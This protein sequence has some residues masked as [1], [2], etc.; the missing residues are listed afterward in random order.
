ML[1][2]VEEDRV[3]LPVP[4]LERRAQA[5]DRAADVD[6]GVLLLRIELAAVAAEELQEVLAAVAAEA[7]GVAAEDLAAADVEAVRRRSSG[8]AKS[9]LELA[10]A[11]PAGAPGRPRG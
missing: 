4:F 9:A 11:A 3:L 8:R 5:A 1:L 2:E 7:D 10:R 6:A